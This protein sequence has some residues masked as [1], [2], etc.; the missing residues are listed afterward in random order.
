MGALIK[1]EAEGGGGGSKLA[2]RLE[3]G[4]G[5]DAWGA[6]LSMGGG[7]GLL[8]NCLDTRNSC[9]SLCCNS[10]RKLRSS[11]AEGRFSGSDDTHASVI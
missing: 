6:A 2:V 7:M 11:R 3:V 1:A 4:G 8:F 9:F 10:L 5:D